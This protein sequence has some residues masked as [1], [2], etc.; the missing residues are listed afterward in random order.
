MLISRKI[1]L[2]SSFS[3]IFFFYR[4][5]M[6][7]RCPVGEWIPSLTSPKVPTPIVLLSSK[8]PIR[9]FIFIFKY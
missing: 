5:L 8:S 4:I 7:T 6:A 1:R 9:F 2:R 3:W